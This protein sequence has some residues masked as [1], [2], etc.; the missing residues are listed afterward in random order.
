MT[1]PRVTIAR[2]M[3]IVLFPGL[4]FAVLRHNYA[5]RFALIGKMEKGGSQSATGPRQ[6]EVSP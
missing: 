2:L 3:A 4:G 5:T 1:R 6:P